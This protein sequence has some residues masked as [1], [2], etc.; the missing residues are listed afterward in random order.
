[1]DDVILG[2]L[3]NTYFYKFKYST[4]SLLDGLE[5]WGKQICV[6]V[7][8]L[9]LDHGGQTFESHATVNVFVGEGF[10]GLVCLAVELEI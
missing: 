2:F 6:V 10:Q 5:E 7:G 8:S 9:V 4:C 3:F 1:M